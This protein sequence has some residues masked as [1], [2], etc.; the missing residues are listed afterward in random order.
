MKFG[1]L[2]VTHL[3]NLVRLEDLTASQAIGGYYSTVRD[4]CSRLPGA[5][6]KEKDVS[7]K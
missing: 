1:E 6:W 7:L 4:D 2:V 5:P 3:R